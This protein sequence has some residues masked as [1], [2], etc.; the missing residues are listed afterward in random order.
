MRGRRQRQKEKR[1]QHAVQSRDHL[2]NLLYDVKSHP[3]EHRQLYA[4]HFH[5][6]SRR[7]RLRLS[8]KAKEIVCRSCSSILNHGT[9]SRVRLRN[10]I[11]IIHCLKCESV[12]RLPY[13][14]MGG[15]AE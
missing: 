11:K 1:R 14:H 15:G 13:K 4:T 3:V 6:I 10:G 9:T 7:N 8:R 5:K 2:L 12:R